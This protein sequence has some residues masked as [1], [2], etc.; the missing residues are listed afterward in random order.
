MTAERRWCSGEDSVGGNDETRSQQRYA[1]PS[2]GDP[3]STHH[4]CLMVSAWLTMVVVVTDRGCST[5]KPP[6]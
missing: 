4:R 2:K 3:T 1:S 6:Q 5:L